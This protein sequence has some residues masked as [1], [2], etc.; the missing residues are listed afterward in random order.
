[1]KALQFYIELERVSPTVSRQFAVPD[2]YTFYQLHKAIQGA[3]GWHN[4]HLFQF[5]QQD[6][7]ADKLC[8]GLPDPYGELKFKDA[9]QAAIKT[10]FKS[11]GQQYLYVYDFGDCW[12]HRITFEKV[13]DDEFSRPFCIAATGACP[14]EDIGGSHGYHE[15]IQAIS[16]KG[17]PEKKHYET[18]LGLGK[19]EKWQAEFCSVREVNARL[20][21]LDSEM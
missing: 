19:G 8:Y 4:C 11:P 1:M 9:R 2:N 20:G 18:W 15:M 14:P 10:V 3:F 17:H 13:I 21:L 5:S 16:T 7:M 12:E 6:F